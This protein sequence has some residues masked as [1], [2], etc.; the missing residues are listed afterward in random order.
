MHFSS[1]VKQAR[2][3]LRLPTSAVA[4]KGSKLHTRALKIMRSASPTK[5]RQPSR[6]ASSRDLSVVERQ[7]ETLQKQLDALKKTFDKQ[8]KPLQQ[9]L[10][11]AR[12]AAHRAQAAFED[13]RRTKAGCK[14]NVCEGDI[15]REDD[16]TFWVVEKCTTQRITLA[17]LGRFKKIL[18]M[19]AYPD[20]AIVAVRG[21]IAKPSAARVHVPTRSVLMF[22]H[23]R[24]NVMLFPKA[25][26]RFVKV[27]GM[28]HKGHRVAFM[29]TVMYPQWM[30]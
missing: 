9:K 27:Y 24:H 12:K 6:R 26:K 21:G 16:A 5:S 20:R 3:E 22:K 1:A 7:C 14:S 29:Y 28:Q 18:R 25:R 19:A 11:K 30:P 8:C 13:K 17:C 23:P 15:F 4:R 10:S 2:Q